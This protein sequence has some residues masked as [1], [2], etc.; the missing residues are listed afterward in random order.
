MSSIPE[1]DVLILVNLLHESL[2]NHVVAIRA[3]WFIKSSL[4]FSRALRKIRFEGSQ[5]R[6]LLCRHYFKPVHPIGTLAPASED[7]SADIDKMSKG[8]TFLPW[9]MDART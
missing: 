4:S 6:S 5:C 1:H 2:Y 7:D 8:G 3:R 9:Q